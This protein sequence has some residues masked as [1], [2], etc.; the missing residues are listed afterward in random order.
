[1]AVI[2]IKFNLKLASGYTDVRYIILY[3]L[4]YAWNIYFYKK[5]GHN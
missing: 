1:M 2:N 5:R 3:T 4:F